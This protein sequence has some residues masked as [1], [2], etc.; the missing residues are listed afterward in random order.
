MFPKLSQFI[1]FFITFPVRENMI[2]KC[3][4][5]FKDLHVNPVTGQ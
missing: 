3:Q 4:D 1:C 5:F 2:S